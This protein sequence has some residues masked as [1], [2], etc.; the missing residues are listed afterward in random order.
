VAVRLV[1]LGNIS[2]P[3]SVLI[4]KAQNYIKYMF[5]YYFGLYILF[6][7]KNYYKLLNYNLFLA[8]V[9]ILEKTLAIADIQ[10]IKLVLQFFL[11]S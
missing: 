11:K 6:L 4:I 1:R 8:L 10:K 7:Y 2:K 3:V 9:G 5:L